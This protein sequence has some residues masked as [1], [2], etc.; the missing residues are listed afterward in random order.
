MAVLLI[1]SH[2]ANTGLSLAERIH[3][4]VLPSRKVIAKEGESELAEYLANYEVRWNESPELR[5]EV[6]KWS[7]V[8]Y[9]EN[10]DG[11]EMSPPDPNDKNFPLSAFYW[12]ILERFDSQSTGSEI[13]NDEDAK[14]LLHEGGWFNKVYQTCYLCKVEKPWDE[15]IQR[16]DGI[17]YQMCRVC[18]DEVQAKKLANPRKRLPH[19]ETHRTCY[20]CMRVLEVNNFIRRATGTYYS[21]CK[22]CN[23]YTF[24]HVRRARKL[25]STGS[26]T[27][28]EFAELLSNYDRCPGCNRIWSE[29]PLPEHMKTPWTADHVVP[30]SKGG[31]NSID[32]IQPLCFSCN[33][34]KGDRVS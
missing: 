34:K 2:E 1:Y 10:F 18:N 23:R 28:K 29:I 19:T 16:K 27:V 3:T 13:L 11:G 17:Y 22:E 26:F 20:K 15:F 25:N 8:F 30:I 33:S 7:K 21:A 6:A 4:A 32:N 14:E 5:D 9:L 12:M 31:L 24:A